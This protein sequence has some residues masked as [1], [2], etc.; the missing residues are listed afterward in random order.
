MDDIYIKLSLL[1][2]EI[3][4]CKAAERKPIHRLYFAMQDHNT[5]EENGQLNYFL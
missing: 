1:N 5:K 2:Y 3:T 4:F